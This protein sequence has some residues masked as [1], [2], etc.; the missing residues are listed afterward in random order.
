[1]SSRH[2]KPTDT[3]RIRAVW[4]HEL[5]EARTARRAQQPESEWAHLE[6]AHIFSQPLALLHT[7][8]HAHMLGHALR[9]RDRHELVG[10]L[11][12]L[13][14]AAPGSI[15]R[16]YPLGNTGGADVSAFDPMPIPADLAMLLQQPSRE[17]GSAGPG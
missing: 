12:R 13:L 1:M 16:R 15:S 17:S 9:Q 4:R 11:F 2:P 10:Q 7:R 5:D 8:T 6:R 14:V 3:D